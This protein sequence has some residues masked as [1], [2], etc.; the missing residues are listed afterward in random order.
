MTSQISCFTMTIQPFFTI[1]AFLIPI[2]MRNGRWCFLSLPS[3]I[4]LNVLKTNCYRRCQMKKIRGRGWDKQRQ[5]Q[6]YVWFIKKRN[7]LC[8][9]LSSCYC[10]VVYWI[11]SSQEKRM[12]IADRWSSLIRDL[13]SKWWFAQSRRSTVD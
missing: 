11:M 6:A 2:P 7:L 5:R 10:N 12:F 9:M 1:H 4:F 13:W 3:K 8:L